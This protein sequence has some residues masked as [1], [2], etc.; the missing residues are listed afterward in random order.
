MSAKA[1]I[2]WDDHV[3]YEK[4][5]GKIF[6]MSRP[7]VNHITVSGNIYHIFRNY[8][9]GKTC[10]VFAEADLYLF[11]D[12]N[13]MPDIMIVCN[14]D[15]IRETGIYG[16]PDLIVEVL[17]PSTTGKD[18]KQKM[19]LYEKCGVTEYWLVSPNGR[20]IEVYLLN[21]GRLEFSFAAVLEKE[22]M[23]EKMNDEEKAELI[24]EFKTSL[25]DDLIIYLE[26]VF[27]GVIDFPW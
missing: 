21:A 15:I 1:V 7:A 14:K 12:D 19:K 26:D 6:A 27:E 13:V 10:K 2:H 17:S 4:I 5:G 11:E 3:Q 22:C 18:K 24:F 9:K 16:S 25:F 23:I 8:L 20:S